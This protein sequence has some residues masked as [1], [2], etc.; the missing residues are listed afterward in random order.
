MSA[1]NNHD[2]GHCNDHLNEGDKE[3]YHLIKARDELS[4]EE[5][6]SNANE[7]GGMKLPFKTLNFGMQDLTLPF[8]IIYGWSVTKN[9]ATKHEWWS[10]INTRTNLTNDYSFLPMFTFCKLIFLSFWWK[11][12]QIF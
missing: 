2:D 6:W 9:F 1:H 3:D 4:K 11:S 7:W 5:K 8:S 12:P 10:F